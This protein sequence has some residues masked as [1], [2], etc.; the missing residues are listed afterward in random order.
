[1]QSMYY[2]MFS[3][4]RRVKLKFIGSGHRRRRVL[5]RLGLIL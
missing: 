4:V 2:N 5:F 1:M 3:R